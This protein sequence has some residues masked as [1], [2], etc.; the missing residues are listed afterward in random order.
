MF[1]SNG[2]NAI[3]FSWIDHVF[4]TLQNKAAYLYLLL[5]QSYEVKSNNKTNNTS[6]IT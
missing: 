6:Y 3:K 2:M 1:E 5:W 4:S